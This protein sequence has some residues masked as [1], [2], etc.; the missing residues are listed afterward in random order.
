MTVEFESTEAS[1]PSDSDATTELLPAPRRLRRSRVAIGTGVGVALVAGGVAIGLAQTSASASP[2][3]LVAAASSSSSAAGGTPRPH[4]TGTDGRPAIGSRQPILVG[5]VKT[6]KTATITITDLQGFTRT[7]VTLSKTTYKDGLTATP[8]V[9]T[10]IVAQGSID[11]NGT[12]L[13][14]MTISA[15]PKGFAGGP[16]GPGGG[17]GGFGRGPAG[18]H[19]PRATG[20]STVK[21]TGRPTGFPARPDRPSST[22]APK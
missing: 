11:S 18:Q 15:L 21:P 5:S 12:S 22:T 4:P 19:D 8:A 9:G 13:D 20:T 17:P 6:A 3:A 16:A 14:A 1:E 2:S 7:I 10:K